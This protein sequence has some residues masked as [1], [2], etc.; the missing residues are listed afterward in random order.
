MVLDSS[1]PWPHSQGTKPFCKALPV[2]NRKG[3]L[4]YKIVHILNTKIKRVSSVPSAQER[5]RKHFCFPP[6]TTSHSNP[7]S[8]L[9]SSFRQPAHLPIPLLITDAWCTTAILHKPACCWHIQKPKVTQHMSCLSWAG[10]PQDSDVPKILTQ[11]DVYLVCPL[12][13]SRSSKWFQ[14][15][16][17]NFI[18]KKH[19]NTCSS[20]HC[21]LNYPSLL[22]FSTEFLPFLWPTSR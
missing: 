22:A 2:Q 13:S 10:C 3:N 18:I 20:N 9:Y 14:T 16:T 15:W 8:P 12:K 11:T 1:T 6:C 17:T 5:N 4:F 21:F 7:E 19:T